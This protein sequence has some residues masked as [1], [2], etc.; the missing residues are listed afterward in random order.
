MTL[1][2]HSCLVSRTLGDLSVPSLVTFI[3]RLTDFWTGW[4]IF[5][6]PSR[7][8]G[9]PNIKTD[10]CHLM[11]AL[12]FN[13]SPERPEDRGSLQLSSQHRR[14]FESLALAKH[15][16]GEFQRKYYYVC[17]A[18]SMPACSSQNKCWGCETWSPSWT[19]DNDTL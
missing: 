11:P 7:F 4:L 5:G 15:L 17:P 13:Q 8:G 16:S 2:I 9:S 6:V 18:V 3:W 12:I 10:L 19:V 1:L 14:A